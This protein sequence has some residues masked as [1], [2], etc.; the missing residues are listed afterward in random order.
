MPDKLYSG[1]IYVLAVPPLSTSKNI[2]LSPIKVLLPGSSFADES[3]LVSASLSF[4]LTGG[5]FSMSFLQGAAGIPSENAILSVPFGRVAVVKNTGQS[6]STGGLLSTVSGP[7]QPLAATQPTYLG[8][9]GNIFKPASFLATS[10]LGNTFWSTLDILVRTFVYRGNALAGVQQLASLLQAEVIQRVDGLY[11]VD[12]GTII[13]PVFSVVKSDI[14]SIQQLIDYSLDNPAVLNPALSEVHGPGSYIYD[15]Q[16]AQKQPKFTVQ[17][18]SPGGTGS[19]DFIPIPDGWLVDGSFEEWQ[20]ASATDL[21]NP[22]ASVTRY[23]KVFPSPVNPGM[24]RGITQFFQIVK[25]I[26]LPKGVSPFVASPITQQTQTGSGTDFNFNFPGIGGNLQGFQAQKVS[27]FDIIS[28]QFLTLDNAISLSGAGAP[29][30]G[31]ADENFY[32]ITME[33]WTFPSVGNTSFPTGAIDPTNPFNIPKNVTVVNPSNNVVF[34]GGVSALLQY[35][36]SYLANFQRANSPRLRT[37]VSVLYRNY[38]PQVGDALLIPSGAQYAN[39]GRIQSV[40]LNYAR[41]GV[42]I[43]ITAEKYQFPASNISIIPASPGV[44]LN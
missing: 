28:N 29:I 24:M 25:E 23:W 11:V 3:N 22:S 30:S 41:G 5:S 33:Q 6:N 35:W 8:V 20:P 15:S 13:G 19:T 12:P 9:P 21:S 42:V 40:G 36:N 10:L 17:A 37:T 1:D 27:F 39:C 4:T 43:N 2:I 14:V 34:T 31:R 38:L 18:G 32:S 44:P 7:I 26:R 16:H